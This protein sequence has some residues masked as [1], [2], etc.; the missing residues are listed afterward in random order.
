MKP[1]LWKTASGLVTV[2]WPTLAV[3]ATGSEVPGLGILMLKS[4]AALAGV[5]ALFA[6]AIWLIRRF[7]PRLRTA[8]KHMLRVEQRISLDGKNAVAVIRCGSQRWLIGFSAAGL[9]RIDR[10]DPEQQDSAKNE[11]V[12]QG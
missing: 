10:L 7:Q 11:T 4:M 1:E 5:L 3:A 6:L 12:V 9:T 8:G 2:M